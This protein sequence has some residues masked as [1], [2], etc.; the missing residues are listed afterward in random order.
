MTAISCLGFSVLSGI[1][2]AQPAD[3]LKEL[4]TY[5]TCPIAAQMK[6]VY[7]RPANPRDRSIIL[8]VKST[9]R[10]YVR[11][12]FLDDGARLSCQLSPPQNSNT[13]VVA[14]LAGLG[15]AAE[16][17]L[18]DL[19]HERALAGPP[20]FDSISRLMLTAL[21]DA[22]G[23]REETPLAIVAPYAGTLIYACRY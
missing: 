1:A 19:K 6:A 12:D 21:H 11:C 2:A 7:E 3:T 4:L 13:A 18:H 16:G 23:V 8:R 5:N 20:D 14:A 10:S 17:P 22:H 15:F 9:P